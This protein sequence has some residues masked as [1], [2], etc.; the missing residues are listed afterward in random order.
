MTTASP[1]DEAIDLYRTND[2]ARRLSIAMSTV[3]QELHY[4]LADP[5]VC[6]AQILEVVQA[7]LNFLVSQ[8][9][10]VDL[11]A[12]HGSDQGVDTPPVTQ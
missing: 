6:Q 5:S 2:A 4:S 9:P 7:N 1:K 11:D 10:P 12:D 3:S 8:L